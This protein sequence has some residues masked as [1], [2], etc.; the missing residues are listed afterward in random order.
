MS[1]GQRSPSKMVGG[2]KITFRT[3][4]HT[5]QRCS[6][7]S[8]IPCVHKDPETPQRLR[9]NCV[10]VSPEEAWVSSGLLQELWVWHKLSWRKSRLTPPQ[11]HQNLHRTGET[12]SWR[13][14][15]E[16]CAYQDPGEQSGGEGIPVELFQILK[17]DAGKALD[18][19]C[20]QILKTQQ[21]PQNW[22]RPVFI[23]I[24]KKG[25]A[26]E[27]SNYH[28]IAVISHVSQAMLKILQTRLQ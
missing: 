13:A 18:S 17:D 15:T 14:Q 1:K 27:C 22:K 20:Q 2:A 28:T 7:G 23:P 9:Q 24:P 5:C 19:I 8:N 16:P 21:W 6:E 4:P 26:K 12:D 3:K 11:S 10:W 25:N